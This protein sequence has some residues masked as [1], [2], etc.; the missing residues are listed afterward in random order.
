MSITSTNIPEL[1]S[2]GL[3]PDFGED[4]ITLATSNTSGIY[5][6]QDGKKCVT[7]HGHKDHSACPTNS[8][9]ARPGVVLKKGD[10]DEFVCCPTGTKPFLGDDWRHF[11]RGQPVNTECREHRSCHNGSCGH[12]GDPNTPRLCCITGDTYIGDDL[13]VFCRNNLPGSRCEGDRGCSTGNCVSNVCSSHRKQTIG[14][15]FENFLIFLAVLIG[16]II[17]LIIILYAVRNSGGEKEVIEEN[18]GEEK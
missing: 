13:R 11:C 18:S 3:N 9:C 12:P 5:Q 1:L 15:K 17:I 14:T 7:K 10:S 2:Y 6:G 4:S 16:S 8:D